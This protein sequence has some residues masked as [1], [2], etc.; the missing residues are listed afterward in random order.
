LKLER[1]LSLS[2]THDSPPSKSSRL[3]VITGFMGTG[4]TETG[5]A[6]AGIL[7]LDY[8]DMDQVIEEREGMTIAEIFIHRGEPCFR[9]LEEELTREIAGRSDLVVATGGGTLVNERNLERFSERGTLVLLE[10]SAGAVL[11]RVKGDASRP[12]LP[13][14][15]ESFPEQ[16]LQLMEARR[17][18]YHRIG[19]RVDTTGLSAREAACRIAARLELPFRTIELPMPPG[20]MRS[21]AGAGGGPDSSLT[22]IEIGRGL[23]S[24]LGERLCA[25]GKPSKV[26]LLM[27]GVVREHY[28]DQAA[29]SLDATSIPWQAITIRDGD[30]EKNLDQTR[31]ILDCFAAEGAQRDATAVAM[32]GGVTGDLAGFAA[33]I[34]MRGIP[35]VQVPTTLLAQVDASIGGKVGVNHPKAK[36]LIG[37]FY[38]PLLTLIDPCTMRTLPAPEIANGMAEVV[39][40]ALLGS[41]ELFDFL[42]AEL[43]GDPGRRLEDIAFLER[44]AAGCAAIK[45]GIVERDPFEKDERRVLNLGHT[46]GHALEALGGYTGLT[47]GQ[48]VSIGMVAAARIAFRRGFLSVELLQR[49]GLLLERC[50]LPTSPP[51][52]D[53]AALLDSLH[54]DKKKRAGKLHFVL[55]RRPGSTVIVNDVTEEEALAA[56]E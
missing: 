45:A 16:I 2:N 12:L 9:M 4:K 47:H 48:A 8:L 50:G 22:R 13:K 49:L 20:S 34:Y 25:T 14:V 17:A 53:K 33:S 29:A 32:G 10:A 24:R 7:G 6:L 56:L 40:T 30:E 41:A 31:E 19:F 18:A 36:N 23:L 1:P 3:V 43:A 39:K 35:L 37:N 42:E 5:R 52:F 27:P 51:A 44:C 46:L 21:I 55:P 11:E 38:A 28:L 54:L 26:F 15:E